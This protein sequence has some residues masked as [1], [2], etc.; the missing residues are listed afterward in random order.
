MKTMKRFVLPKFI[1]NKIHWDGKEEEV[2]NPVI[3]YKG[4]KISGEQ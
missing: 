4:E 3:V 2:F 1:V